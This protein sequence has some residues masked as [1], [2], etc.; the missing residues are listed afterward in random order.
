MTIEE[1]YNKLEDKFFQDT[2]TGSIFYNV[3]IF[4]Y[5]AEEEY[6]IRDQIEN[7]KVRLKRP[8]NNLD[9]LSVNLFEEFCAFLDKKEFGSH[10]SMLKYLL[11]IEKEDDIT[12]DL[13]SLACDEDFFQAIHDKIQQHIEDENQLKKSF[14]FL[15]GVG[16]IFPYLR[17]NTF[18]SNFERYNKGEKYKIIVF[19]PGHSVNNSFSLFDRLKDDNT[20]RAIKLIEPENFVNT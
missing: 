4:Q 19:Y 7:L 6:E 11:D 2:D 15:Y 16:Q 20:Y 9:I 8:N 1:L 17:T 10:P 5:K 3:Y 13:V 12:E 18:L 14:V